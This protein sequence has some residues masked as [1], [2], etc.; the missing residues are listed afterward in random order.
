MGHG[1]AL[2]NIENNKEQIE[3]YKKIVKKKSFCKRCRKTCS[4]IK[5]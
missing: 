4:N 3:I 5:I 2:V 1:R